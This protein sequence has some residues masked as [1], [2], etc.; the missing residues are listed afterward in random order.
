MVRALR[1]LTGKD[2][3]AKADDWRTGLGAVSNGE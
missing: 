2:F 3:G 1:A